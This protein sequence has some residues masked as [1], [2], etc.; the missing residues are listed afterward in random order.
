MCTPQ[1]IYSFQIQCD[2]STYQTALMPFQFGIDAVRLSMWILQSFCFELERCSVVYALNAF[3]FVW[4]Y[5]CVC[6]S[7]ECCFKKNQR[8]FIARN[9]S[10]VH[11]QLLLCVTKLC[12]NRSIVKRNKSTNLR[13]KN[14]RHIYNLKFKKNFGE[15]NL[16]KK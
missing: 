9:H 10:L 5:V 2:C 14:L 3:I 6:F 8:T 12:V 7:T 1:I 4:M 11:L 15:W 16:C 13:I